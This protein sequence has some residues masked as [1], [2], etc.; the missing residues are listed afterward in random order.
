V[1]VPVPLQVRTAPQV[2]RGGLGIQVQGRSVVLI[3]AGMTLPVRR[4]RPF[5]TV[6]DG[7]RAVEVQ[8]VQCGRRGERDAVIGRFLLG[9]VIPGPRGSARI[10]IG[11]SLDGGGVLRAWAHDRAT[12][13]REE[14][15]FGAS[16]AVFPAAAA[17][18][19]AARSRGGS[20]GG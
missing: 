6:S 9:G 10:D 4:S 15:V 18:G 3:P 20:R 14:C 12:G 11:L 16:P 8:V 13:S 5:T 1:K 2:F 17:A 7:Q 19:A